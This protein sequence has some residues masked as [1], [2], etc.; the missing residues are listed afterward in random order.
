MSDFMSAGFEDYEEL[1]NDLL[2]YAAGTDMGE[3]YNWKKAGALHEIVVAGPM[4]VENAKNMDSVL[5]KALRKVVTDKEKQFSMALT[6]VMNA[7]MHVDKD[8]ELRKITAV[9]LVQEGLMNNV[10]F[11]MSK[12]KSTNGMISVILA[13]LV[14]AIKNLEDLDEEDVVKT[15][16][17]L[18]LFETVTG[19]SAITKSSEREEL[20]KFVKDLLNK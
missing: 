19:K 17:D 4:R 16:E 14:Q 13:L 6:I 7:L 10:D 12:G 20:E 11:V 2:K 3:N 18:D 5:P 15:Q 9:K 1:V 8:D